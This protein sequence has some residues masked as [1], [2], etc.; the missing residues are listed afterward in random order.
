MLPSLVYHMIYYI[1]LSSFIIAIFKPYYVE[2][3]YASFY[4][5]SNTFLVLCVCH[6]HIVYLLL[7]ISPYLQAPVFFQL[8]MVVFF[9]I[10]CSS[11]IQWTS[12]YLHALSV[13][14]TFSPEQFMIICSY[15]K[16]QVKLHQYYLNMLVISYIFRYITFSAKL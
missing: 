9:C 13:N 10:I 8:F 4:S 11:I 2:P 16:Q 6:A 15:F 1:I 3:T 7:V 12:Y 14:T 5:K